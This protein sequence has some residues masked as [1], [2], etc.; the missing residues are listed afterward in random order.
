MYAFAFGW[1][2]LFHRHWRDQ[3][4]SICSAFVAVAKP[5]WS[6]FLRTTP[7]LA[8]V[9]VIL[10]FDLTAKSTCCKST[11]NSHETLIESNKLKK[12]QMFYREHVLTPKRDLDQPEL[13]FN[14][15][16]DSSVQTVLQSRQMLSWHTYQKIVNRTCVA[17]PL[18]KTISARTAHL[19]HG[20][21]FSIK[22]SWQGCATWIVAGTME[23]Q[24]LTALLA[25]KE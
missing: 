3:S 7:W 9:Y 22:T 12:R 2:S 16:N 23:A 15:T 17:L 5:C 6:S 18:A 13:E 21:H 20:P 11:W 19:Q 14:Q 8:I 1:S 25:V 4:W 10:I 24:E